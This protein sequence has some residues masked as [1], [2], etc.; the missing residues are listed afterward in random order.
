LT[1]DEDLNKLEEGLRRLRVEYESYFSGGLPK[2]P[3][4]SAFRIESTMK[5]MSEKMAEFSL[6]Q[7]FRF[8]QLQQKYM[9]YRGLWR[10]RVRD[11]E[12]GRSRQESAPLPAQEFFRIATQSPETE[13][14]KVNRL[15]DALMDAKRQMGES[16]PATDRD[17]FSAFVR[18]KAGEIK[19]RL[20]CESVEFC[21]TIEDG[22]VKLKA[23]RG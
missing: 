8:N 20:R 2:P 4:D 1:T 12:E 15:F 10:K 23:G 13:G 11:L 14:D 19:R 5:R 21:V 22:R 7:R 17:L 9:V 16:T 6:R 18:K 3:R